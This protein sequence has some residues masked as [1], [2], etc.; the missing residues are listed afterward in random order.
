MFA[1]A[2][3]S[4]ILVYIRVTWRINKKSEAQLGQLRA[5]VLLQSS[6]TTLIDFKFEKL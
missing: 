6:Q 5:S 1:Y 4:Q 2:R 3:Y